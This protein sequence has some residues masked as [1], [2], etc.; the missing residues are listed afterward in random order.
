MMQMQVMSFKSCHSIH[1]FTQWVASSAPML[2]TSIVL[3][4][5]THKAARDEILIGKR[6]EGEGE[7][8]KDNF[9]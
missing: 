3:N 9:F 1:T 2:K 5:K 6:G 8:E 7:G 4:E